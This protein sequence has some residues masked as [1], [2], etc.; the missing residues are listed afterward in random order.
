MEEEEEKTEK[1]L[2]QLKDWIDLA[3]KRLPQAG[4]LYRVKDMGAPW[5]WRI[6]E[7]GLVTSTELEV[8]DCVM[9]TWVGD[10]EV[11]AQKLEELV[12]DHSISVDNL[13]LEWVISKLAFDI[14]LLHGERI[15]NDNTYL[16]SNWERNFELIETSL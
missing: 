7:S 13:R 15:W 9:V 6:D 16:L 14:H 5:S 8:G 10:V 2:N 1:W 4:K 11:N 12:E 3:R